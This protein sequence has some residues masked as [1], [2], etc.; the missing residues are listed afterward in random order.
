M[1]IDFHTHT[2]ME[3]IAARALD[4]MRARTGGVRLRT[5]G[6]L[7]ALRDA[8]I[9]AGADG[10]VVLNVATNPQKLTAVNDYAI[11][12]NHPEALLWAFGSVHPFAPNALDELERL[13]AHGIR[14]IK[15]QPAFQQFYAD[16]PRTFPIYRAA[17]KLGF[18]TVFH[19]GGD[20]GFRE[21][22]STP[23]ALAAAIP[24][25][26]GA[27]VVAAHFGGYMLWEEA[28][29]RLLPLPVFLDTSY[30]CGRMPFPLAAAMAEAFGPD[31][32]LFGSDSPWSDIADEMGF[33]RRMGFSPDEEEKIFS[34]NALRL[35]SGGHTI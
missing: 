26:D 22:F 14:G 24:Q 28:L 31:R 1:V 6:T 7:P 4:S 13:H 35:L 12:I 11:S 19:A 10:A 2:F 25:F 20:L 30:S 16:D 27:P 17:A 33:I 32:L 9:A 18:V 23:Q 15:F 3:K 34:G 29:C 8:L 21:I 5:D